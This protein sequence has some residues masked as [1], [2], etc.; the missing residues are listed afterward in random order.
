MRGMPPAF[1]AGEVAG[2]IG[3]KIWRRVLAVP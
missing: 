2:I 3:N 1:G